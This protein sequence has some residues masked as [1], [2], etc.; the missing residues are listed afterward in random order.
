MSELYYID[1]KTSKQGIDMYIEN[2]QTYKQSIDMYIDSNYV[3][4]ND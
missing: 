4:C 1:K 2:K 3:T